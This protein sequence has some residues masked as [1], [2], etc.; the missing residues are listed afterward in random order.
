[1]HCVPETLKFLSIKGR[2]ALGTTIVTG[3]NWDMGISDEQDSHSNGLSRS[4]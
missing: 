3:R 1:M 2:N 4:A